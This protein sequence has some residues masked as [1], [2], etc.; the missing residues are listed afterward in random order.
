MGVVALGCR[1]AAVRRILKFEGVDVNVR[2]L[3]DGSTP[4]H[5]AAGLHRPLD[6]VHSL[7]AHGANVHAIDYSGRTPLIGQ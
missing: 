3:V 5:V 7:L 2:H 6:A 1:A 4:L